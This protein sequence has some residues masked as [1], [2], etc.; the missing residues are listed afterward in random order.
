MAAAAD[1]LAETLLE[2]AVAL[3]LLGRL[4]AAP[5]GA[6]ALTALA[7]SALGFWL[8]REGKR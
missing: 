3:W 5:G 8:R 2:M 4:S 7:A 6:I 1:V